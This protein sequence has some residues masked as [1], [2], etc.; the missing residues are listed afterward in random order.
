MRLFVNNEY[1][2]A[3]QWKDETIKEYP[4]EVR[5][6]EYLDTIEVTIKSIKSD[7]MVDV[8]AFFNS[9]SQLLQSEHKPGEKCTGNCG[10]FHKV[11]ASQSYGLDLQKLF[12]RVRV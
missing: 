3:I 7:I 5:L 8:T 1:L 11:F 2:N 4:L 6:K 10:P 9:C 12:P